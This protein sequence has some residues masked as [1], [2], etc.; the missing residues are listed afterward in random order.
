MT[1][2]LSIKT[3][4]DLNCNCEYSKCNHDIITFERIFIE[5]ELLRLGCKYF[6]NGVLKMTNEVHQ[7]DKKYV[8]LLLNKYMN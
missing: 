1:K 2:T 7:K 6:E 5:T 8:Q 4:K 3:S